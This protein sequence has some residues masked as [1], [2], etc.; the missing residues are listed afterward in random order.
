MPDTRI[1]PTPNTGDLVSFTI[2]SDGES[3]S[4][5]HKVLSV[6]VTREVNRVTAAQIVLLD[7]NLAESDFPLS[8]LDTFLP[9]KE[10]E[11]QMGYHGEDETVFKGI[12]IKQG[13]NFKSGHGSVLV[14]ECRDAAIKLTVGRKNAFFEEVKDADII[15]EIVGKH[16]GLSSDVEA[17]EAEHPGM[18]QCYTSDWDFIVARAEANG[19]LVFTEDGTL[20]VRK[21]DMSGEPAL[22]LIYGATMYEFDAEM[23]AR[24][25]YAGVNGYSWDYAGQ[26]AVEAEGADPGLPSQGNMDGDKLSEV[27]GLESYLLSHGGFVDTP[28]L[29][30]WADSTMMR[31]RLAKIC[32]RVKCKGFAAI[33]PGDVIELKGVGERFSGNAFVAGVRQ[34]IQSNEWV[35]TIEFGLDQKWFYRLHDDFHPP[36]AGGLVSGIPGLQTGT[37]LQL[38]EDPNGENRILINVPFLQGTENQLWARVSTLDAGEERGSFFLPEIGDEVILGFINSDPR[39]PV[40]L[41]MLHSSAKPAPLT[42]ADDNH[43][44]GFTTR[45][46]IQIMFDDDKITLTL[47]TPNGNTL[48]LSDDDGGINMEDENG[49]VI[50]LSSD[51]ITIE[52]AGDLNLTTSTGDV[53]IEGMNVSIVA[54]AEFKAEGSAGAEISTSA[55]AVLKGSLVQIN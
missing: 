55:I 4:T 3:L 24:T 18:V 31:S 52:S 38:E 23:D 7:G 43:E 14:V 44:K 48:L 41:G 39:N 1:I 33:N 42:A 47:T 12:V 19:M 30:A 20:A 29:Q 9:G 17:T 51:G 37:V 11:I 21:P 22:S 16:S 53:N 28:E 10:I 40:V 2:L 32:G 13:I 26:E 49:N 45:S 6:I 36:Q 34:E 5:E 15:E 35:T 50:T 25:Q 27:I 54:N 46:G 8:N